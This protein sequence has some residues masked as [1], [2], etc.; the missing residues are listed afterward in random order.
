M[1]NSAS[2]ARSLVTKKSKN[3]MNAYKTYV[4]VTES[5]ELVLSNL[6]FQPGQKVEVIVIAKDDKR[7]DLSQKFKKLLDETQ[8]IPGIQD[9]TE[10]EI[11][12]EIEAY[13]RGE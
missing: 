2:D 7:K 3:I 11:A 5:Q 10:E 9:I 1:A 6:P 4:T 13:R 12:A 8:A